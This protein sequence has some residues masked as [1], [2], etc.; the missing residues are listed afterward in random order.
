MR[1][2][3]SA[4]AAAATLLGA[5]HASP[6]PL[7][8]GE[9][10][11]VVTADL[12]ALGLAPSLVGTA[13]VVDGAISFPI[14][15]GALDGV[16]GTIEHEGSG[17]TLSDGATAATV[18]N[19][20]VDTIQQTI[21][22]DVDLNGARIADDAPLFTFDASSVTPAELT[23]LSNPSL[24]LLISATLAGTLTSAFGAA[25]LTG[26]QFGLA[27]TLPQA[28]PLPPALV[29]FAAGLAGLGAASRRKPAR[30]EA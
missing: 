16:A 7:A 28:V 29:L 13:S 1:I 17:V 30:A 2:L 22:G 9:T 21:F 19:F 6:V 11:V 3:V 14:T 23:D 4:I 8:G 24:A 18:G 27:A 15:G 12:A 25:D 26:V 20:I 10:R 5:A